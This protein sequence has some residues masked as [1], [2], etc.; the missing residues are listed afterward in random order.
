MDLGFRVLGFIGFRQIQNNGAFLCLA[1]AGVCKLALLLLQH[2][3]LP[4]MS[5]HQVSAAFWAQ[6]FCFP[7]IVQEMCSWHRETERIIACS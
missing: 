6:G 1:V 5:K 2:S 3:I 4:A 7:L